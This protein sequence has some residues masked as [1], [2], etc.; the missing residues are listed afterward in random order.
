MT[1]RKVEGNEIEEELER[2]AY[3]EIDARKPMLMDWLSDESPRMAQIIARMLRNP[4]DLEALLRLSLL[5]NDYL[6][7]RKYQADA[8]EHEEIADQLREPAHDY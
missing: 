2:R 5:K 6:A 8:L 1:T 4:N 7:M 3:A